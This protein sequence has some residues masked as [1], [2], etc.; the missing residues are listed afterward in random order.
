LLL[1]AIIATPV[2]AKAEVLEGVGTVLAVVDPATTPDFPV[3][4]L[5]RADCAVV[6]RIPAEDGSATE[7][8]ACELSD[9]PVMIPENQGVPPEATITYGGGPCT[10]ISDFVAASEGVEVF[11]D[12]FEVTV[13]PGGHVF[14]WSTYAAEPTECAPAEMPSAPAEPEASPEA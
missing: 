2:A 7:W 12:D 6:V 11:A 1:T 13:T 10:W 8:M 14:A 4:S 9:E 5:M 3:G